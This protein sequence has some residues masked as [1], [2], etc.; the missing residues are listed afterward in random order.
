MSFSATKDFWT[1]L[2]EDFPQPQPQANVGERLT[3]W[4][5]GLR[6]ALGVISIASEGWFGPRGRLGRYIQPNVNFQPNSGFA[7]PR[8]KLPLLPKLW[9]KSKDILV[10]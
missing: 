6:G 2:S 8:E 5:Y 4:F 1:I 10:T 3:P 7:L 9:A